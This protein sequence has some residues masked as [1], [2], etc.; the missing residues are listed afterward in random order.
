MTELELLP[1]AQI[2]GEQVSAKVELVGYKDPKDGQIKLPRRA[3]DPGA[4]VETVDFQ[5]LSE[6]YEFDEQSSLHIGNLIGYERG[7]N[8]VPVYLDVNRLATEHLAVL[9]MMGSGK[10]YAVGRIIERLVA[11]NNGTAIVFDPHREYGAAFR[12]GKLHVNPHSE[13][14]E[15]PRDRIR[16]TFLIKALITCM[17]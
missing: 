14:I 16:P 7:E 6:F 17:A 15:D 4:N 5:F 12:G 1:G 3:L 8:I 11:L 10:S 2:T 9:A 13:G